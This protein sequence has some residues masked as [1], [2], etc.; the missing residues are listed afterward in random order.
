MPSETALITN[1]S[2]QQI[3]YA[4]SGKRKYPPGLICLR[5]W[6][7]IQAKSKCCMHDNLSIVFIWF[8]A[9]KLYTK[10]WEQLKSANS[11]VTNLQGSQ[12]GVRN[13]RTSVL[14]SL[15]LP[16]WDSLEMA[17]SILITSNLL[18]SMAHCSTLWWLL[19]WEISPKWV[20]GCFHGGC[21][22]Q[23][24]VLWSSIE[25]RCGLWVMLGVIRSEEDEAI[26]GQL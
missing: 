4:S 26:L 10:W 13:Q 19:Q 8:G 14:P 22:V 2:L 1:L 12:T 20:S 16:W 25:V 9:T 5:S 3:S 21:K 11:E 24:N 23:T 15:L 17:R 7:L 6:I 18:L